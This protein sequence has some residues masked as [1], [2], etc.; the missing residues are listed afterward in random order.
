VRVPPSLP[1]SFPSPAS[2]HTQQHAKALAAYDAALAASGGPSAPPPT[3]AL[4]HTARAGA[5]LSGRK[6]R[7]AAAAAALALAADPATPGAHARRARALEGLGLFKAALADARAA[8]RGAGAG[9][10]TAAA[11][12][13]LRDLVAGRK[14]GR[15]GGAANGGGDGAVATATPAAAAQAAQAQQQQQEPPPPVLTAKCTLGSEARLVHFYAGATFAELADAVAAKF[16]LAWGVGEGAAAAAAAGGEAAGAAAAEAAAAPPAPD[17]PPPPFALSFT[18]AAGTPITISDRQ[19][20]GRAI[21]LFVE[22]AQAAALEAAGGKAGGQAAAAAA[23]R[24]VHSQLSSGTLP[25]LELAVTPAADLPAPPPTPPP[26]ELAV[27]TIVKA[28][29]AA[30]AAD[31]RR[32]AAAA[33]AQAAAVGADADAA[34]AAAA[35]AAASAA[36]A[37]DAWLLDFAALV[38]DRLGIDPDRHL[39]LAAAGWDRL[40][41]A[42]EDCRASPDADAIFDAAADKF[43]ESAALAV[44]QAGNVDLARAHAVLARAAKERAGAGEGGR[45]AVA[46]LPAAVV[47]AAARHLDA[48]AARYAAALASRPGYHE[49]LASQANLA[50]ERVKLASGLAVPPSEAVPAEADGGPPE[51]SPAREAAVTAAQNAALHGALGLIDGAALKKASPLLE[52]A[53][54]AFKAAEAAVPEAERGRKQVIPGGP[55][56]AGDASAAAASPAA[57][58]AGDANAWANVV[59]MWGNALFEASQLAAAAAGQE[60]GSKGKEGGEAAWRAPLDEA[61]SKFRE[62]G[63]PEDDITAALRSHLRAGEL[64]LPP[65]EEKK[66]EKGE[67]TAKADGGGEKKKGGLP[68]LP[69]KKGGNK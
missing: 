10:E 45:K 39:D 25:P 19:D 14:P 6:F 43:D 59:V 30:R 26:E 23:A 62:A 38:R 40:T 69:K 1:T 16:G 8:N 55:D 12:A 58:P 9:A 37:A 4:L 44:V 57:A 22:A 46:A 21:A 29:T 27:L 34:E 56:G 32:Y 36:P 18:D 67:A 11:E 3:A 47:A 64:G 28:R 61:V 53:W 66:E 33:A 68:A 50:L 35:A 54:A 20:L 60:G 7:E 13:R 51:G 15:S 49:A 63:C 2:H 24:A 31:L 52:Q 41:A 42:V 17:A 5:L 65:V 48:A